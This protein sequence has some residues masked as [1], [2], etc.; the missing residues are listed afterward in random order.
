MKLSDPI[1]FGII[2]IV[3]CAILVVVVLY[4]RKKPSSGTIEGIIEAKI[5]AIG[6]INVGTADVASVEN[7][8]KFQ[9]LVTTFK[10]YKTVGLADI[11]KLTDE[12][13]RSELTTKLMNAYNAKSSEFINLYKNIVPTI[14]NTEEEATIAMSRFEEHLLS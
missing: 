12:A 10:E 6:A 9:A 3:I 1:L 4:M 8:D 5:T 7:M 2:A 14:T 11:G 13:K